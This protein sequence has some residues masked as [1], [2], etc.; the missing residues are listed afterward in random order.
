MALGST[1]ARVVARRVGSRLVVIATDAVLA[2]FAAR[3]VARDLRRG[4]FGQGL[5]SAIDALPDRVDSP[6]DLPL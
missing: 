5:D 4:N 2:G 1:A 6:G 3:N